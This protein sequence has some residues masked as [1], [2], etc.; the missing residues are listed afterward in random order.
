MNSCLIIAGEKSGEEHCLSFF[1]ELKRQCPETAFF[2]VG[3]DE[4]AKEGMDLVYHLKDFSSWGYS[5]VF[6]KIPFY[7]NA[8]NNLLNEA[9]SRKCKVA[10]LID[11]QT[12]NMRLAEKLQEHG[13]RVLYMVAPQAWAWKS[14]R[15]KTLRK[16]VDKLYTII[17]FEKEWFHSRGV[18]QTISIDHPL[19]TKYKD[20][21]AGYQRNAREDFLN[22]KLIRVLLLPGSRNFE[23]K[24]LLPLFAKTIEHLKKRHNIEVSIVKSMSVKNE[25]YDSCKLSIQKSFHNTEVVQ[26][27]QEADLCLAASGTVTLTC[28]L[29][30]LPTVV[31]YKGSLLNQ[32]IYESFVKYR[33]PISLSNIVNQAMYFPEVVQGD[34]DV[35]TLNRHLSSWID[36]TQTYQSL[37]RDLGQTK[38]VI[39]GECQ[40]LASHFAQELRI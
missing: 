29:F 26:A 38:N 11:F 36:D 27:I 21:L 28:G 19:F 12:F 31:C 25:I 22:K 15:V 9:I 7:I 2:G 34:L 30:Q 3:G 14:W 17:P 8:S 6:K 18:K 10:I 4:L 37:I 23:V 32:W 33:G 20:E 35:Y 13:I 1:S 16:V 5:E 39:Q 24:N 40:D